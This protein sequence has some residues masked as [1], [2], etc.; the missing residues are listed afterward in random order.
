[1]ILLFPSFL[2]HLSTGCFSF[3][4]GFFFFCHL[5]LICCFFVVS[6]DASVSTSTPDVTHHSSS[7][8]ATSNP[9]A[10]Y[11]SNVEYEIEADREEKDEEQKM[12]LESSARQVGQDETI[13]VLV[14]DD[15]DDEYE[16]VEVTVDDD[17]EYEEVD[18]DALLDH[19]SHHQQLEL[20][21]LPAVDDTSSLEASS[22]ETGAI[23]EAP[24]STS[25]ALSNIFSSLEAVEDAFEC[26]MSNSN[27]GPVLRSTTQQ[28]V[29]TGN[30]VLATDADLHAQHEEEEEMATEKETTQ[31]EE[32]NNFFTT[33]GGRGSEQQWTSRQQ[34]R[35]QCDINRYYSCSSTTSKSSDEDYQ[36]LYQCEKIIQCT[37]RSERERRGSAQQ[38]LLEY[39]LSPA[40]VSEHCTKRKEVQIDSQSDDHSSTVSSV[41]FSAHSHVPGAHAADKR[42]GGGD[43]GEKSTPKLLDKCSPVNEE[44]LSREREKTSNNVHAVSFKMVTQM[45]AFA[46]E[47]ASLSLFS[48]TL[49]IVASCMPLISVVA[50]TAASSLIKYLFSSY[51]YQWSLDSPIIDLSS[52]VPWYSSLFITHTVSVTLVSLA[53]LFFCLMV[54]FNIL[55]HNSKLHMSLSFAADTNYSSSVIETS[56]LALAFICSNVFQVT[57]IT[58]SFF[59]SSSSSSSS[60]PSSSVARETCTSKSAGQSH[61]AASSNCNTEEIDSNEADT[62]SSPLLSPSSPSPPSSQTQRSTTVNHNNNNST[63]SNLTQHLIWT[64]LPFQFC[65]AHDTW[66][67]LLTF[68]HRQNVASS[69]HQLPQG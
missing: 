24:D 55:A 23:V 49:L 2:L 59:F 54:S 36:S 29:T 28:Q 43:E 63:G 27:D 48:V 66:I 51:F 53:C 61:Y 42:R 1:M 3:L 57:S 10:V 30:S 52:N 25:N 60:S 41:G 9:M 62:S 69:T 11:Q 17:D 31:E 47:S 68:N 32:E 35:G 6:S 50:F 56:K 26:E 58:S 33:E 67:P 45:I 37:E 14:D 20:L 39:P 15:D 16:E 44:Q 18:D 12:T 65:L 22:G 4:L 7:T 21:Q 34:Q 64:W 38:F 5:T 46:L 8:G 40:I 19:H 13:C